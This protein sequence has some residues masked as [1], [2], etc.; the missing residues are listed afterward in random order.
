MKRP[1]PGFASDPELEAECPELLELFASYQAEDPPRGLNA[2]IKA[3]LRPAPPLSFGGLLRPQA[4]A[5]AFGLVLAGILLV[6]LPRPPG[7]YPVPLPRGREA[8]RGLELTRSAQAP[9]DLE[10][11]A[12]RLLSR[13]DQG[14]REVRLEPD[15]VLAMNWLGGGPLRIQGPAV[16]SLLDEG[17][18]ISLKFGELES[19]VHPDSRGFEVLTPEA[20]VQVVG[21]R[22]SVRRL[23]GLSQRPKTAVRVLEGRVR[24]QDRFSQAVEFLNP[25]ESLEV[26]EPIPPK[27]A[28]VPSFEVPP[29]DA[30]PEASSPGSSPSSEQPERESSPGPS[31]APPGLSSEPSPESQAKSLPRTSEAPDAEEVPPAPEEDE[32]APYQAPTILDGF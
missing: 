11:L 27:A 29:E 3:A 26:A 9:Q 8:F 15:E 31:P 7:S 21:T 32:E 13:P 16:F 25:G 12:K 5:A 2:N 19:E 10:G 28:P 20:R 14:Y 18:G 4:W 23:E 30:S 24:V 6:A 1:R 22:F 17:R